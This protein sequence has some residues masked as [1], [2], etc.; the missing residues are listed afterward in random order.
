MSDLI[1]LG[2]AEFRCAADFIYERFG[3]RLTDQ[4]RVLVS[5][6]LSKRLRQL[7]IASFSR[8]FELVKADES[9]AEVSELLNLITTNHSYFFREG[10]HFDFLKQTALPRVRQLMEKNPSY[11]LRIWSAGCAAGEEVYT[12]AMIV[13]EFFGNDAD[14]LDIGILAS[15]ISL[16]A[17]N[18]ARVGEYG[19]ARLREMPAA[20]RSRYLTSVGADRFSVSSELRRMVLFKKLN[21]MS[22]RFPFKSGFDVIFCR[23]VM[24]YFDRQTQERVIAGLC[25]H[26]EPGGYLF[27]GHA[28]SL[29][30]VSHSLE[31]VRPAVYRK[32][33]KKEARWNK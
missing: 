7:G 27:V 14:L 21:L 18:E 32:P 10:D 6:R 31:Y 24:I 4:K 8:Y 17:L 19:E 23:N 28:E 26:L 25:Q 20:Y 1:H 22:D 33:G 16:A 29:T 2:D 30:R 12:I 15:D 5:G 3:I 11:P 9:G 13:R